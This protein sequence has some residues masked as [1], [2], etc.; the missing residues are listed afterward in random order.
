[1][2]NLLF[3]NWNS[4]LLIH[5][6]ITAYLSLIFFDKYRQWKPLDLNTELPVLKLSVCAINARLHHRKFATYILSNVH[7]DFVYKICCKMFRKSFRNGKNTW[8]DAWFL[9][10]SIQFRQQWSITCSV[11]GISI[12]SIL[13]NLSFYRFHSLP[14]TFTNNDDNNIH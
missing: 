8:S 11:N 3:R 5:D 14:E 12:W 7:V 13:L 1:M 10:K 6:C 9:R 4:A 2:L